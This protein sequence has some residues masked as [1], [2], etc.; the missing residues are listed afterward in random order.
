MSLSAF[1]ALRV[2]IATQHYSRTARCTLQ[3]PARRCELAISCSENSYAVL[4]IL[5]AFLCLV[6]LLLL[7][8][9]LAGITRPQHCQEAKALG[10]Y[11]TQPIAAHAPQ[12]RLYGMNAPLIRLSAMPHL[13]ERGRL[14]PCATIER[15][16]YDRAA[17]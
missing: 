4:S 11:V 17:E 15:F 2:K 5:A 16:E 7:R 9:A 12:V 3:Q 8:C 13:R 10:S 1:M 14:A 6:L